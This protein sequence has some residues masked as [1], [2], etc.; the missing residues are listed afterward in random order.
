MLALPR[1]AHLQFAWGAKGGALVNLLLERRVD[2]VV[3]GADDGR[4]PAANVIDVL[5]AVDVPAVGTLEEGATESAGALVARAAHPARRRPGWPCHALWPH[6]DAVEYDGLASDGLE[7]AHGRVDA[8]REQ[9]L[10]L[11]ENLHQLETSG[12]GLGLALGPPFDLF[13]LCVSPCA[14]FRRSVRSFCARARPL[15]ERR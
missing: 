4:A 8:A 11:L 9:I 5:V 7:R 3:A 12:V 10:G 2:L 1:P 15:A 13:A 6:L 14:I